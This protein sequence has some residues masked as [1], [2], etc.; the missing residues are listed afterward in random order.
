MYGCLGF[1]LSRFC[2]KPLAMLITFK[3]REILEN[4]VKLAENE[5]LE[6]YLGSIIFIRHN[7][8]LYNYTP[9]SSYMISLP[10]QMHYFVSK[11][12]QL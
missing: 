3:G 6:V 12:V 11:G 10:L 8:T 1:A 9:S 7:C 2:A 5:N 4:T